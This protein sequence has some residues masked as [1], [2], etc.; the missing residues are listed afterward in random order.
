MCLRRLLFHRGIPLRS[1]T[2]FVPLCCAERIGE[3]SQP[4]TPARRSACGSSVGS[5]RDRRSQR[6]LAGLA[7]S[8]RDRRTPPDPPLLVRR[9][10]R[11]SLRGRYSG[12]ASR[13]N[14][15]RRRP[16][17]RP[18]RCRRSRSVERPLMLRARAA[19]RT[20]PRAL[21]RN[22]RWLPPRGW[23]PPFRKLPW[24]AFALARPTDQLA[25]DDVWHVQRV[26]PDP[27]HVCG[28]RVGDHEGL[29]E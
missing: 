7:R 25:S 8:Q 13:R 11:G 19:V 12:L 2:R 26:P 24:K 6:F 23:Q 14:R 3:A 9:G 10:P 5:I 29:R 17:P 27:P 18:E 20:D 21:R 15:W 28:C 4:V 22:R 1:R 16:V